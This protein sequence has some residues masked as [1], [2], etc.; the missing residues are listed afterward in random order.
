[1]RVPEVDIDREPLDAVAVQSQDRPARTGRR[2]RDQC[3][4]ADRHK[5]VGTVLQPVQLAVA[6]A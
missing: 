3:A 2:E 4:L 6:L 1:M 5:P